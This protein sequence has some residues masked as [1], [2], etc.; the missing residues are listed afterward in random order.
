MSFYMTILCRT[1][2]FYLFCYASFRTEVYNGNT[3][4]L[5]DWNNELQ[6]QKF[7]GALLKYLLYSI[8]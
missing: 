6:S 2:Q 8:E 5:T 7:T 3:D 4:T 1:P